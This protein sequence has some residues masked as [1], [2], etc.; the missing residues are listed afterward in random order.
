MRNLEALK[1]L[2]AERI[3]EFNGEKP[4]LYMSTVSSRLFF[5]AAGVR[6]DDPREN[7]KAKVWRDFSY[8]STYGIDVGIDEKV[9]YG[10][11][12]LRD[13]DKSGQPFRF[14]T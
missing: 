11:A 6:N 1:A 12:V 4:T 8:A 10:W 9:E 7:I 2:L 3:A 14:N 5:D 13:G